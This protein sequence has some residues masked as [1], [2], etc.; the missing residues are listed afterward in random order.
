[1]ANPNIGKE[2]ENTQWKPGQ[3]GNPN[4]RPPKLFK[5]ILKDFK[6]RGY[7]TPDKSSTYDLMMTLLSLDREELEQIASDKSQP[8]MVSIVAN[9]LLSGKD[10]EMM[11]EIFDRNHGKPNTSIT[12]PDGSLAPTVII[13][14]VYAN[15]PGFRVDNKTTETDDMAEDSSPKQS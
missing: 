13:E 14:G 8:I 6:E 4:G 2:G 15:K 3:S 9:R 1:M 5:N 11:A 7:E 12:N 10:S